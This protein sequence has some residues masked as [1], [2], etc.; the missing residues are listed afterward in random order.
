MALTVGELAATITVD[1]TEAEQGLDGFQNR[2]RAAL[3]RYTQR[4][5]EGGE[6]AG[7]ALGD[8]LEEGATD[9]AEAAGGSITDALKGLAM[10]AIGAALGAALMGG[11]AAAMD[12]EQVTA[13]LAAQLGA[14]P[15]EAQKY[16]EVAGRLY[17]NAITEDFQTAA[18]AIKATMG[19]GLVPP[20]ATNAQIESISTKAVDLATTFDQEVG[21]VTRAVSQLLRT[22]LASSA[23]EAFDILTAGFQSSAN[24][25]DD[26]LDTVNEYATQWRRVGLDGQT[27][28][29]LID[30]GMKAGARDGDQI[31]DAIGQFGELALSSSQG[32][33]DAF[34]SIGLNAD[35]MSAK[36]GKGGASA[37][38]A[39][40]QTLDALRGTTNQQTKLNAATALFG[41]PGTV[42]GDALFAL[43]PA[44]AA[45]SSGMDKAA[46]A[47]DRLGATLHDTAGAKLERFKR[48]MTQAFVETLGGTVV[49]VIEKF[50]G[51]L[52]DHMAEVKLA[53]VVILATIVPA[54]LA[55]GVQ[56]L[57]TGYAM[58]QAWL[59]AM[60]PIGW[61]GLAIGALVILVI[62]YWDEIKAFTLA[63]W[64]WI[65]AKVIWAKD[66]IVQAFMNWTLIGLLLSHW[67]S[68]KSTAVT[69]WNGI[70]AWV[71]GIPGRMYQ[72]F[73]NWTLLGLI[74]SHWSA[75]K[76]AT[77]NKA[78]DLVNWVRGLPKRLS[79]GMGSL[80]GL[81]VGKGQDLIRGLYDG[82]R[83]MGGWLKSQLIGFA[84]SMIPGPIADA[85]GI[86][87]PSRVL[88]DEVGQWIPAGIVEG[89]ES[90]AGA[91]DATMRNLVSVPT[92][93]QATAA[94]VAAA[95]GAV[96]RGSASGAGSVVRIGS[97]GSALGDLIIDTLRR[98][99]AATGGDVQFAITGKAA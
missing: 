31:A 82:V 85:L 60:G 16:G 43:D 38:Q 12:Q 93:G 58:A 53:A 96:A 37:E 13:K 49:P 44:T 10:G 99:V 30:Q 91:V 25:G 22:G 68:I 41:D 71:K 19:S 90:G 84:K 18:D 20:D 63:A 6:D 64:D 2:L 11:I 92:A 89:V 80:R 69:W 35:D 50:G 54:L 39:L 1:D 45:A 21:G 67:S 4:A 65:V 87:S 83:G 42:M 79:D 97:D 57:I 47:T 73:L 32:V 46:G 52:N 70:V 29:G 15:A 72:A 88:R 56:S 76:T 9:G 8:G 94:N 7:N 59:V 48:G 3:A 33:K 28:L 17:A 61:I 66:W 27:A 86:H 74:I 55:L 62:A 98:A 26:L 24:G 81:L 5:R 95:S 23:T 36:I 40:Q 14:T 77:V 51:F 75:I 78:N 34:S